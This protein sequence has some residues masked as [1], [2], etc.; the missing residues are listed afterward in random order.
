MTA[1]LSAAYFIA[2][3]IPPS[4]EPEEPFSLAPRVWRVIILTPSLL[5][6]PPAIPF[7]PMPLLL[8]AAMVP[9]T[10]VPCERFEDVTIVPLLSTK[11]NP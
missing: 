11:L 8:T 5:P 1:P 7:T 6:D 2:L 4:P 3:T 9:A 10:W